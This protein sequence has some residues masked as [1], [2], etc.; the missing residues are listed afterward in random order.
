MVFGNYAKT[1]GRTGL[2]VTVIMVVV[3]NWH[4]PPGRKAAP[5]YWLARVKALFMELDD[6]SV[7]RAVKCCNAKNQK[8]RMSAIWQTKVAYVINPQHLA[9]REQQPGITCCVTWNHPVALLATRRA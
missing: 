6:T 5:V 9:T 7:K 1:T 4:A 3:V 8:S 2:V